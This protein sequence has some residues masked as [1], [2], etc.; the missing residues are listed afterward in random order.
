MGLTI[1]THVAYIHTRVALF[2]LGSFF[3]ISCLVLSL[4]SETSGV[5]HPIEEGMGII[6]LPFFLFLFLHVLFFC[7]SLL[8]VSNFVLSTWT[9]SRPMLLSVWSQM[10]YFF[11]CFR[12]GC[13]LFTSRLC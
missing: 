2:F 7:F 13:S 8:L 9:G 6:R 1:E 5:H 10:Y 4:F 12:V 11:F 3:F